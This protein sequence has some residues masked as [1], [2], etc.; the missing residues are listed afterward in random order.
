M[1]TREAARKDLNGKVPLGS[2]H[3]TFVTLRHQSPKEL[4]SKPISGKALV[5]LSQIS[6]NELSRANA[7]RPVTYVCPQT[8]AFIRTQLSP[9]VVCQYA[10]TLPQFNFRQHGRTSR[11]AAEYNRRQNQS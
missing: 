6:P 11:T 7:H 1:G 2:Q 8:Y 9:L 5:D 10:G 4:K 3:K